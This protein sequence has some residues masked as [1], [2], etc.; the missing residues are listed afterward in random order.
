MWYIIRLNLIKYLH[1]CLHFAPIQRVF[2]INQ[3]CIHK[4]FKTISSSLSPLQYLF[5]WFH[6]DK[7]KMDLFPH[8]AGFQKKRELVM[9]VN[10]I[11]ATITRFHPP[12]CRRIL[13]QNDFLAKHLLHII[14]KIN[15]NPPYSSLFF[16]FLLCVY[17]PACLSLYYLLLST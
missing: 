6:F 4:S 16:L 1:A 9:Y 10:Q 12:A 11:T 14:L 8:H 2:S 13:P 5:P 7:V 17:F 3:A 15:K